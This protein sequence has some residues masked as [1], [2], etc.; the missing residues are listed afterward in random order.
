MASSDKHLLNDWVAVSAK[1]VHEKAS[2]VLS[3]PTQ[4]R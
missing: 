1:A 3:F 2:A 4:Y